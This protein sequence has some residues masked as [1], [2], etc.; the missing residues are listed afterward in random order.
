M[1]FSSGSVGFVRIE[2][3]AGILQKFING[4]GFQSKYVLQT[5]QNRKELGQIGLT[6]V[7][8]SKV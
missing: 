4:K 1:D 6:K 3:E 7:S 8:K 5:F 2:C